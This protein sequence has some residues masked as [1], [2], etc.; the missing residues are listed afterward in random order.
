MATTLALGVTRQTTPTTGHSGNPTLPDLT[1]IGRVIRDRMAVRPS[2]NL[3]LLAL[4]QCAEN[5]L[6]MALHYLRTTDSPQGIQ[7]ATAKAIRA[8]TMLKRACTEYTTTGRTE[9]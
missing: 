9:S 4:R 6:S 8:T 3:D 7:T 2:E 5:A 1:K